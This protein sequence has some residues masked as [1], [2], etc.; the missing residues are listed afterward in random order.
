M[1][2][3][4][5][6][7]LVVVDVQGKLFEAMYERDLLLQNLVRIIQGAKALGL[8][9]IWQEQVPEKMGITVQAVRDLLTDI[10]PIPK[11]S[12]SCCGEPAF[13]KALSKTGRKQVIIAGIE[14]HV[15]IYQTARDLIKAGYQVEVVADAVSSRTLS[16]KTV[17]ID[18]I[19]AVGGSVTSVEAALFEMMKGADDP[20]FREMLKIVR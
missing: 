6:C 18:K 8:P 16:N 19:K 17:G 3:R 14:T 1:L 7:V 4:N 20:A 5:N 15:C 9:V 2:V 11:S 13:V 10:T 12:F